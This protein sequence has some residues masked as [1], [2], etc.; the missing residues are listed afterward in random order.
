MI[1]LTYSYHKKYRDQ[2]VALYQNAFEKYE[3]CERAVVKYNGGNVPLTILRT[4]CYNALSFPGTIQGS[5]LHRPPYEP[6]T[7]RQNNMT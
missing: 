4:G 2:T 6:T 7:W 5:P 3:K 1:L